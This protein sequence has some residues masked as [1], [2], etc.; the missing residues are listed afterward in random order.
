MEENNSKTLKNREWIP[1]HR[2]IFEAAL[3][4]FT[5]TKDSLNFIQAVMYY[6]MDGKLPDE[7]EINQNVKPAWRFALEKLKISNA[8]YLNRPGPPKGSRN[9]PEGRKKLKEN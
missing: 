5:D 6:S 8:Q 1:I 9:N 4:D 2:E 7:F 3:F